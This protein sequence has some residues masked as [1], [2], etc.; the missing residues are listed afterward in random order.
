MT[1]E[2]LTAKRDKKKV[3]RI[4]KR[5][6]IDIEEAKEFFYA[7]KKARAVNH[8]KLSYYKWKKQH[9]NFDDVEE[10]DFHNF[11]KS[12]AKMKSRMR[13]KMKAAIDKRKKSAEKKSKTADEL[14][15]KTLSEMTP[16]PET[17]STPETSNTTSATPPATTQAGGGSKKKMMIIAGVGVLALVIGIVILKRKK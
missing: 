2:E 3:Y 8:T 16:T 1:R 4:A 10:G 5:F 13:A 9:S 17:T 6:D 7:R 15:L 14:A 12:M 11:G